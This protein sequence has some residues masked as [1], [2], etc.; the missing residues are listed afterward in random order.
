MWQGNYVRNRKKKLMRFWPLLTIIAI[1]CIVGNIIA[2]V[3]IFSQSAAIVVNL[4]EEAASAVWNGITSLFSD[5]DWQNHVKEAQNWQ[6]PANQEDLLLYKSI[7]VDGKQI[8]DSGD[9]THWINYGVTDRSVYKIAPGKHSI[10]VD[11]GR[12]VPLANIQAVLACNDCGY[13]IVTV[14]EMLDHNTGQP[15]SPATI[16]QEYAP[17][18]PPAPAGGGGGG[19]SITSTPTATAAATNLFSAPSQTGRNVSVVTVGSDTNPLAANGA[20][21]IIMQISNNDQACYLFQIAA[22][23]YSNNSASNVLW[24][25]K[26]TF[27]ARYRSVYNQSILTGLGPSQPAGNDPL[28]QRL[29]HD[30]VIT[31]TMSYYHPLVDNAVKTY[32]TLYPVIGATDGTAPH[33]GDG[34]CLDANAGYYPVYMEWTL[35]FE[36][37]GKLDQL[38]LDWLAGNSNSF[39]GATAPFGGNNPGS[40]G[41]HPPFARQWAVYLFDSTKAT[42]QSLLT[43]MFDP[44]SPASAVPSEGELAA[45]LVKRYGAAIT[46][47]GI[48]DSG[49]FNL[50]KSD[51]HNTVVIEFQTSSYNA[52]HPPAV[53]FPDPTPTPGPAGAT[54]TPTP[55][56]GSTPTPAPTPTGT[57]RDLCDP[58]NASYITPANKPGPPANW[59]NELS[60]L[61]ADWLSLAEVRGFEQKPPSP[62]KWPQEAVLGGVSTG[63]GFSGAAG[64]FDLRYGNCPANK[65]EEIIARYA[66]RGIAPGGDQAGNAPSPNKLTGLGNVFVAMGQKYGI[67]PCYGVAWSIKETQLGTTGYHV[68]NAATGQWGYNLYGMTGTGW[69]P[70]LCIPGYNGRFCGYRS[71]QDSIE[72]WFALISQAY[73]QGQAHFLQHNGTGQGQTACPCTTPDTILPWYAPYFENDTTLYIK[74]IKDWIT[75]WDA[76]APIIATQSGGAGVLISNGVMGSVPYF[77]QLDATQ[78]DSSSQYYAFK[79]STCGIASATMVID[80]LGFKF[81]IGNVLDVAI[82]NGSISAAE[83]TLNWQYITSPAMQSLGANLTLHTFVSD[84][85]SDYGREF[86]TLTAQGQ[87]VIINV[88]DSYFYAGHFMVVTGYDATDDTFI[89]NDPYGRVLPGNKP[90]PPQKW[91]A[92]R[93]ESVTRLGY[94]AITINRADG[95][96]VQPI[97]AAAAANYSLPINSPDDQNRKDNSQSVALA[98]AV[99]FVENANKRDLS[100]ATA[101]AI[102]N[103][104]NNQHQ[105][106][107]AQM[108]ADKSAGLV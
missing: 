64:A 43:R 15:V 33:A 16:A 51:K 79:E 100:V 39:A 71:W 85:P 108:Y 53:F 31:P 17:P 80:S 12:E 11:I 106:L 104:N 88:L 75:E 86:K 99:V 67:N 107:S 4:P 92:S 25:S 46:N 21:Y 90:G 36:A 82:A 66:W 60:G 44:N 41:Y 54:P 57:Y 6:L 26:P 9:S 101:N 20:R 72:D 70:G 23:S 68:F 56:P 8:T 2:T 103:T 97:L 22:F 24:D 89:V 55:A 30:S 45:N 7:Y 13:S 37:I 52:P 63:M 94:P 91:P 84:N 73:V 87:P 27:D 95:K 32:T 38:Q 47:G 102:N 1:V 61:P 69:L 40:P 5:S 34:S 81:S 35:P 62:E 93:L 77:S 76:T 28:G 42:D 65:I 98:E 18:P 49:S 3:F 48:S 58:A 50:P 29:I 78:Y 59:P 14:P 83:G 96:G 105:P 19:S 10:L 74:Q